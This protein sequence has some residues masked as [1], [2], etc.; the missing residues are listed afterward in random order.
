MDGKHVAALAAIVLLVVL[1]AYI[2]ML[3]AQ[4]EEPPAQPQLLQKPGCNGED[5]CL[6]QVEKEP[7]ELLREFKLN[8]TIIKKDVVGEEEVKQEIQRIA[9]QVPEGKR[10]RYQ[11][12]ITPDA[13]AVAS[14][15][16]SLP[17]DPKEI[18]YEAVRW[19][20][21][22]EETL[23]GV[24][25]KWLKP[26]EFL[27]DTPTYSSNPT[28]GSP[29]SDCSEQANA[30]VSLSR[31]KGVSAKDV[32]AVLGLVDFSGEVGGHVWVEYRKDGEWIAL[33]PT[34]GPYWDDEEGEWVDSRGIAFN[35]FANHEYPALEIW[36]YY[37]DA[38]Y[39]DPRTGEGNPPQ[40][41]RNTQLIASSHG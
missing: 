10:S 1:A 2:L 39:W 11:A 22:S 31:A 36:G 30:L 17:S 7:R 14:F 25:E 16:S 24:Q 40:E 8:R 12:F 32:R 9:P 26:Q 35:Y 27:S 33:D 3:R 15:A 20:W 29:V 41:W 23:N 34:S 6:V 38:Y 21:V 28:P 19:T 13:P 37:N 4:P 5:L 18:Y